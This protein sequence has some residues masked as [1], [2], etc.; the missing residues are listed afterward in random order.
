MI[1]WLVVAAVCA[2]IAYGR[3]VVRLLGAS[4][5]APTTRETGTIET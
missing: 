3:F 1:Y 5:A 2:I 4:R